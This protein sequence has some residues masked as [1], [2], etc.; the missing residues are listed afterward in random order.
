MFH[1]YF[2]ASLPGTLLCISRYFFSSKSYD[3]ARPRKIWKVT[4]PSIPGAL[5]PRNRW[6]L[7]MSPSQISN[8]GRCVGKR[9]A[10]TNLCKNSS[11]YGEKNWNS[12][13]FKRWGKTQNHS[14]IS[15]KRP[16]GGI[17]KPS[18]ADQRVSLHPALWQLHHL[19]CRQLYVEILTST[20][21]I[22]YVAF[23]WPSMEDDSKRRT[24]NISGKNYSFNKVYLLSL[25]VLVSG[26]STLSLSWVVLPCPNIEKRDNFPWST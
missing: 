7:R 5:P 11:I 15:K 18:S 3:L 23:T 17:G 21:Y 9:P 4:A 10:K 6:G 22:F 2:S 19:P 13:L 1:H 20:V 12:F 24:K 14:H 25:A 16:E 8:G 26:H